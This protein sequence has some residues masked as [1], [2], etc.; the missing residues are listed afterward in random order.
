MGTQSAH[1]EQ[2]NVR[3][4]DIERDEKRQRKHGVRL[5]KV[6]VLAIGAQAV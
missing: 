6:G 5:E 4:G 1:D 2:N 3:H